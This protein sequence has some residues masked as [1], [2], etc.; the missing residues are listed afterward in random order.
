[1]AEKKANK[2]VEN[3][4]S[5]LGPLAKVVGKSAE[6]LWK[7]FVWK[8]VAEGVG[9][10]L[11]AVTALGGFAWVFGDHSRLMIIP[12]L[13]VIAAVWHGSQV[14]INPFYPAMDDVVSHVKDITKPQPA[15]L[16][17]AE[18]SRRSY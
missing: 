8:Y 9:E 18:Q 10:I 17:V 11:G 16:L 4:L 12:V 14:L 6:K 5:S 2:D 1:M 3:A 15:E 7:I 13:L